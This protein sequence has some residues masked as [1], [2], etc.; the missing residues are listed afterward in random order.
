MNAVM[1]WRPVLYADRLRR[2]VCLIFT[3]MYAETI[4]IYGV[5]LMS[6]ARSPRSLQLWCHEYRMLKSSDVHCVL[7]SMVEACA[8]AGLLLLTILAATS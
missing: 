5:A 7:F 8:Q 1:L 6:K 3:F 4:E 2:F